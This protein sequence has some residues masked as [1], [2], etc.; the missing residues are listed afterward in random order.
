MYD[1]N[2][3]L[4][5]YGIFLMRAISETY[6]IVLLT[7]SRR[8]FGYYLKGAKISDMTFSRDSVA[9]AN[10]TSFSQAAFYLF[11]IGAN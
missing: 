6:V 5:V 7:Y 4:N 9:L 11:Y 2:F 3:K 1:Y 10:L 8:N